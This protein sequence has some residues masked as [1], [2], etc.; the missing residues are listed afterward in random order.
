MCLRILSERLELSKTTK[1]FKNLEILQHPPTKQL[2][3]HYIHV[4]LVLISLYAS[5]H[6]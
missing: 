2:L 3:D 5:F 6:T 4:S 1:I